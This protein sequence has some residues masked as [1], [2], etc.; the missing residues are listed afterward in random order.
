M[1]IFSQKQQIITG[2][3]VLLLVFAAGL[4]NSQQARGSETVLAGIETELYGFFKTDFIYDEANNKHGELM[5]WTDDEDESHFYASARQSRIGL[6]F[7]KDNIKAKL[8][9]D[10]CGGTAEGNAEFRLRHAYVEATKG[11]YSLLVGQTWHL[12]PLVF[13]DINNAMA[14][15]F[16]GALW[17]RTP[18]ARLT[19]SG[20]DNIDMALALTRPSRNQSMLGNDGTRSGRPMAQGKL[21]AN[22][23]PAK[24]TLSGA[25]G[26]F[27]DE[28]EEEGDIEL[29]AVGFVI[30]V[31]EFATVSGQA[32]TGTNLNDFLG[33]PQMGVDSSDTDEVDARGGFVNINFPVTEEASL[34]VGHGLSDPDEDADGFSGFEGFEKNYTSYGTFTFPLFDD[35]ET[36]ITYARVKTDEIRNHHYQTSFTYNF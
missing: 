17:H 23:G 26:R 15:G 20:I 32:W 21:S 6:N 7:S 10:F 30:P 18:Q 4:F 24:F 28:D 1:K 12:T 9:G 11:D 33:A 3:T 14:G 27:E 31:A 8:E 35:I 25:Y 22:I 16:S 19:Y 29:A 2:I 5:S 13:P 34:S 36:K